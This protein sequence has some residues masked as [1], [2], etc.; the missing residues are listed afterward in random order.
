MAIIS[1]I[2]IL[3]V[4]A[5][6]G[7]YAVQVSTLQ[8]MGSV[9]DLES[10]RAYQAARA[11]VEWALFRVQPANGG[12]CGYANSDL[13]LGGS[14][15]AGLTVSV[16]CS[17]SAVVPAVVPAK[18]QLVE[19]HA[20]ACNQPAAGVCPNTTDFNNMYVERRIDVK[21]RTDLE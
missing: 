9:Q 4:L 19:I 14:A 10:V 18:Y 1:A 12:H 21:L 8:H 20:V 2:I 7:A 13:P 15:F 11:G 5:L 16:T 3:V 17:G 6:L